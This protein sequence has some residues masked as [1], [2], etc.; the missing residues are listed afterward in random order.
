MH[1]MD[2]EYVSSPTLSDA[3]RQY[4]RFAQ[5]GKR[6]MY[7]GGGTEII[8]LGRLH[9]VN[10]DAVIDLK[11]IPETQ[12]MAVQQ[13]QL[14]LGGSITLTQ[15]TDAPWLGEAFPLLQETVHEIADRTAR[16]KITIAGNICGTIFYREA[17]LPFLVCDSKV[18]T[19]GPKRGKERS[20]H[21]VFNREARLEPSEFI[22]QLVTDET[23]RTAPF[24]HIKRRKAGRVGY[25]IVSA[26]AIRIDDRIRIAF[27]GVC[28]FPFRSSAIETILRQRGLTVR[29]RVDQAIQR[30]PSHLILDDYEASRAYRTF[31]LANVL[32]EILQRLGGA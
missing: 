13:G 6:P 25:P 8:T 17:V 10:P 26:A 18:R 14:V 30:I 1:P 4:T 16:N 9:Q 27:S 11:P 15:I 20:I 21:R 3:V 24:V 31:V 29:Q 32:E 22:V 23:A 7:F 12:V 2:F 28:P 5:L 19:Y